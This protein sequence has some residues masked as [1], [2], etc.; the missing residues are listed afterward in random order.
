MDG[1]PIVDI[2]P[3][4]PQYDSP[5]ILTSESEQSEDPI[6]QSE[7]KAD[8]QMEHS[9]SERTVLPDR[10]VEGSVVSNVSVEFTAKSLEQLKRFHKLNETDRCDY[11]LK[12]FTSFDESKN[13]ITNLL[14]ADPRSVY[15]RNKCVDR[16][17]YFTIDSI[18]ITCWFDIETNAVQVV[19]VKPFVDNKSTTNHMAYDK[20]CHVNSI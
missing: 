17:Y 14:S 18:H 5:K 8:Q 4:I 10:W 2:K 1:T 9:I 16:L 13:A 15:R 3:Y 12:H 11:C 6:E 20:S 7:D 19:K